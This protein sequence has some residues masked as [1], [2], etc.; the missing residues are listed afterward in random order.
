MDFK[1]DG[2]LGKGGDV[3]LS[4]DGQ[5]VAVGRVERTLPFRLSL[6]ETMDIGKDT[7]TAVSEDYAVK[8]PFKSMGTLKQVIVTL[9][10]EKLSDA[11]RKAIDEAR[12]QLGL[13]R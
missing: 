4:V 13:S 11:D 9:G 1:Y 3:V 8:M 5:P 7:G 2:T 6:D 12:A 10:E